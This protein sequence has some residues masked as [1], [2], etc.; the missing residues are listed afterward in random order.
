ATGRAAKA[1]L[2][3]SK[4]LDGDA[5]QTLPQLAEALD[6]QHPLAATLLRRAVIRHTLTYGKSKR[7][8]HAARHLLE[9]Q[10][11]DALITDYEGFASHATFVDTLRR[12]HARKPAFWQKLQ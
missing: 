7:Y 11:S 3:R 2:T 10:A 6:A 1:V 4:E 9:C 8:R 12:K 5:W